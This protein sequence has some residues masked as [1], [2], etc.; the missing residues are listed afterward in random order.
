MTAGPQTIL[1]LVAW[2]LGAIVVMAALLELSKALDGEFGARPD[3][4]EA[5]DHDALARCR[6][7]DP[8]VAIGDPDCAALWDRMRDRF[9]GLDASDP[10]G[11]G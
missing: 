6:D 1:R 11:G 10:M 2:A 7:L 8:E 4:L 9:L 5:I 3:A